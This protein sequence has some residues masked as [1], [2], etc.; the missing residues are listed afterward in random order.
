MKILLKSEKRN[1][2]INIHQIG[3]KHFNNDNDYVLL[4]RV[5]AANCE[6]TNITSLSL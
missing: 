4:S 1:Q 6:G 3:E 5:I 2:Y